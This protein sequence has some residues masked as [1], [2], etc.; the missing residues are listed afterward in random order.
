MC[1]PMPWLVH[2]GL[3]LSKP[4]STSVGSAFPR[5]LCTL[6]FPPVWLTMGNVAKKGYN[7]LALTLGCRPA[8]RGRTGRAALWS[9]RPLRKLRLTAGLPALLV[10]SVSSLCGLVMPVFDGNL[11][12]ATGAPAQALQRD[13]NGQ[14]RALGE[15]QTTRCPRN[16]K[17]SH[18][19]YSLVAP[20]FCAS[21]GTAIHLRSSRARHPITNRRCREG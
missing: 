18:G 9:R 2:S 20:Y 17:R 4:T 1:A 12:R 7:S 13:C 3:R 5:C 14:T 21:V 16:R 11:R 8:R 10:S 6:R 15:L 19:S